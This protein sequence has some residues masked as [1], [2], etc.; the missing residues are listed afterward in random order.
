[1]AFA[2]SIFLCPSLLSIYLS[3]CLSVCVCL[4]VK[5]LWTLLFVVSPFDR[6]SI[7]WWSCRNRMSTSTRFRMM[8]QGY[9]PLFTMQIESNLHFYRTNGN[10]TLAW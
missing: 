10:L 7:W 5:P 6:V 1:M 8:G 4:E 9:L 2:F 3:V